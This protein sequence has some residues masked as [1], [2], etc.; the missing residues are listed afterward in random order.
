LNALGDNLFEKA[1]RLKGGTGDAPQAFAYGEQLFVRRNASNILSEIVHEGT[2]G[3]D[4]LRR[5]NGTVHQLEKRA[6]FYERQ[7]QLAG[8]G[9][10]EF[11]T[12]GEMLRFILSAY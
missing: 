7:F 3:L 5:F 10:V 1:W 11:S 12:L 4:Y 6:F 8:G 2:H 9:S